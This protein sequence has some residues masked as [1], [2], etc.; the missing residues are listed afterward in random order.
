MQKGYNLGKK[1][2]NNKI[3]HF[4]LGVLTLTL[5]GVFTI[6]VN[7]KCNDLNVEIHDFNRQLTYFRN[8][9]TNL[10]GQITH[11]NRSDYIV[12]IAKEKIDL[13]AAVIEPDEIVLNDK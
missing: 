9:I 5:V 2:N 13:V 3:I 1:K 6:G 11:L 10:D 7:S 8:E 12:K 4:I